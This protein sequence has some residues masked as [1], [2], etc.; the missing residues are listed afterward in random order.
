[1]DY[2]LL[3][4][5]L[6]STTLPSQLAETDMLAMAD[7][8]DRSQD[9][10]SLSSLLQPRAKLIKDEIWLRLSSNNI[11]VDW[12]KEYLIPLFI[13]AYGLLVHLDDARNQAALIATVL[14]AGERIKNGA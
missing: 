7:F 4:I 8:L 5:N 1:M 3:D 12:R 14:A 6:R 2:L 10:D 11:V 9:P 13:V